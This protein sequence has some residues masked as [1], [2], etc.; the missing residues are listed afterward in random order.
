MSDFHFFLAL[1]CQLAV[2][3]IL[4]EFRVLHLALEEMHT[5]VE[6]R[7]RCTFLRVLFCDYWPIGRL[8][9]RT[10]PSSEG[11][12]KRLVGKVELQRVHANRFKASRAAGMK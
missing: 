6:E 4:R 5:K 2:G 9:K 7:V 1:A 12:Q 10:T 8:N 3:F 11:N